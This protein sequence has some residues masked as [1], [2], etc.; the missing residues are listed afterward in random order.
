MNSLPLSLIGRIIYGI[1]MLMF[2]FGH[3]G[4]ANM[5]SGMVPSFIPGGVFWVYLTGLALL[6]AG[7]SIIINKKMKLATLLLGIMLLIFAFTIHLPNMMGGNDIYA[8]PMFM[9]D[10]GLAGAA[11]F[12]SGQAN[13]D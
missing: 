9:K 11:L 6:A 3:F 8:L 10:L 7:V 5:M 1:P 12:M 13:D 2:A 4:N